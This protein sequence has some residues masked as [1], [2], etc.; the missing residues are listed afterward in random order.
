MREHRGFTLLEVLVA[1][2][3]L[4][5]SLVSLSSSQ[6]ASMRATR[7]ARG[8][9]AASFL[10]EYQL[11]E[12]EEQMRKDGWTESDKEYNG[13]FADQGWP[14]IRYECLVD[15][16]ELPEF[17]RLLEAKT[18]AEDAALEESGESEMAGDNAGDQAFSALGMAWPIAKGAI[19]NSIRKAGCK[20]YWSD[21]EV[22]HEFQVD[23][24]WAEAQR[25]L[26][27][28]NL[29]GEAIDGAPSDPDAPFG[30]AGGSNVPPPTRPSTGPSRPVG[31]AAGGIR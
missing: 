12:I 18:D 28:P 16:I 27:L 9:T 14:D 31:P 23:T 29:G 20:V 13:T 4:G 15:F 21:G 25:L 2:A 3:I 7:Y 6:V 24:F 17:N 30:G 8:L 19:E 10:A 1:I 5:V 11:L 22:E 26:Q